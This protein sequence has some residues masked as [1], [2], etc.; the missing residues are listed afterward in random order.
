MNLTRRNWGLGWTP[1]VDPVNGNPGGLLRMDN[2][3]LDEEGA[4]TLAA[5]IKEIAGGFSDYIDRIYSK[6]IGSNESIWVGLHNPCTSLQRSAAGDFS[7]RVTLASG[8]FGSR[9]CF[10]DGLGRVF[11]V[12][13]DTRL[14]DSGTATQNLGLATPG[15]PTI[16][17]ISQAQL[18]FQGTFTVDVGTDNS[19]DAYG[20]YFLIDHSLS[21]VCTDALSGAPINTYT[22]GSGASG[23]AQND[24]FKFEVI[25]DDPTHV[26]QLKIDIIMNATDFYSFTWA[27]G[28]KGGDP[29]QV[30]LAGLQQVTTL[31]ILRSDFDRFGTDSTQ[32]WSTVTKIRFSVISDLQMNITFRNAKFLGGIQGAINGQY[33]Y[34]QVNRNNTGNYV[35][36]SPIS[37]PSAPVAVLNGKVHLTPSACEAQVT[38][39]WF[40]RKSN[41]TDPTSTSVQLDQYY[42]CATTTPGVAVDDTTGDLDLIRQGIVANQFLKT[43]LAGDPNSINDTII[44][45]EGVFNERMLYLSSKYLY[46]S[47]RLNPD[48]IDSRY[49]IKAFGDPTESNL[50]VRRLTNNVHILATSKNNYEISGTLLDL[51]DGSIDATIVGIGEAYPSISHDNAYVNGKIFY[52]A[53]DGVRYTSGSNSLYLSET[54]RLLF[55]GRTRAGFPPF[56]ISRYAT[57]YQMSAGKTRLYF[58]I[59]AQDGTRWLVVYDNKTNTWRVQV[60]DPISVFATPS[61]RVLLGYNNVMLGVNLFQLDTSTGFRDTGGS[62]LSG[63]NFNFTTVFDDNGQPRNRKDTFTLKL[64]LDTGGSNVTVQIQKDSNDPTSGW[65]TLSN[66]VSSTGESTKYFDLSNI[67]LGFRYAVRIIDTNGVTVFKLYELTI[68]YDPRPEQVNYLRIPN[69]NLGTISRKRFQ[70]YAFVIDTIGNNVTFTPYIDNSNSGV[71]PANSVLSTNG[72]VTVRHDFTQEQLG[73]DIGGILNGGPF[74]FYGPNLEEVVSEKLPPPSKYL[75]IPANDYGSPNRKRHTSYK[76]QI[77][78]RGLNV[79]FTPIVDGVPYTSSTFNTSTKRTVEHYFQVVEGDVIGIDIGGVLDGGGNPF[80]FYHT[81]VPQKIEVLPDRL[82]YLRIP[83]TNLGHAGRKR[84][85]T[86]PIIID[87]FGRTVTFTPLVDGS[88]IGATSALVTNGKTTTYHYFD[89]DVFPVD[90]GGILSCGTGPFEFYDLGTPELVEVLPV[91]KRYDMVGPL[92]FDKVG[93]VFGFRL[94]AVPTGG[95]TSD[96]NMPYTV[97]TDINPSIPAILSN[98]LTGTVPLQFGIDQTIDINFP[99][100]INTTQLRMTLGPCDHPFHRYT[101]QFKVSMSGMESD[102]RWVTAR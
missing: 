50:W 95:N 48:A 8:A 22:I 98:T 44:G 94:R 10:G 90:I 26:T 18:I 36:I 88:V 61:D 91:G 57:D 19:H 11:V 49:I 60:T 82:E 34:I 62:L 86:I 38:D 37:I 39:V 56:L 71:L 99:K 7:D 3:Y 55:Q 80:E 4:V 52:M 23:D 76:F 15:T 78:T 66:A 46:L 58:I 27:S 47:D 100:G 96:L 77:N 35:G 12:A 64:I 17:A 59:P 54:L 40:Y 31:Q 32:D 74:E 43:L 83:N 9:A 92:T 45:I 84:I 2:L 5:G 67:T 70:N 33:L 6:Q 93:K 41:I 14:K 97:V 75:V 79:T 85:R 30:L 102:S 89:V 1:S 20:E 101:V 81:I 65:T 87:T 13:G 69:S 68:E 72:K 29:T 42:L 28:A 16:G 63:F 21:G 24:L 53:A 73:V 51:P 25:P